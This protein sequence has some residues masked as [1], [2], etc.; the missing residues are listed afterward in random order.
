MRVQQW[1]VDGDQAQRQEHMAL[2]T[3]PKSMWRR[4]TRIGVVEGMA[5]MVPQDR[6]R[7]DT[8]RSSLA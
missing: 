8:G 1:L 5:H 4:A 6:R 3:R 7:R 2:A